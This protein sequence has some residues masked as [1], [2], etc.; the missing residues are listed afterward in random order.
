[1]TKVT[2]RRAPRTTIPRAKMV[3]IRSDLYHA[4]S[5]WSKNEGNDI[6]TRFGYDHGNMLVHAKSGKVDLLFEHNGDSLR[7]SAC[8]ALWHL[9]PDITTELMRGYEIARAA[10]LLGDDKPP[11]PEVATI[12]STPYPMEN[13]ADGAAHATDA[14]YEAIRL[15]MRKERLD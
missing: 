10:G 1:M 12:L 2:Q 5:G 6:P 15:H 11:I 14:I 3:R 13:I 8:R 9:S 4:T 7:S